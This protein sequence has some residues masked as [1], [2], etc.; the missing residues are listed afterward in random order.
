MSLVIFVCLAYCKLHHIA[1]VLQFSGWFLLLIAIK[2]RQCSYPN[3]MIFHHVDRILLQF[4]Q[5]NILKTYFLLCFV[6]F[7]VPVSSCD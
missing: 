3:E 6:L 7:F 5:T 2:T 1:S 4:L